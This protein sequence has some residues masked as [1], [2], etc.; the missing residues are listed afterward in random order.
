MAKDA[1]WGTTPASRPIVTAAVIFLLFFPTIALASTPP[2]QPSVVLKIFSSDMDA[3]MPITVSVSWN[4]FSIPFLVPPESIIIDAYSLPEGTLV[5]TFPIHP[6]ENAC[7]TD[8]SCTY[9]KTFSTTDLP[10]GNLMLIASDPLSAAVDRQIIT[11]TW[12]GT[13][14]PAFRAGMAKEQAFLGISFGL[15]VLFSGILVYLIHYRT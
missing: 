5:A 9:E 13:G 11:V 15:A 4:R 7:N 3:G 10:A 8:E 6:G 14:S 12:Q 2:L 1:G